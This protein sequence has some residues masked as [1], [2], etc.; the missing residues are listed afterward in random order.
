MTDSKTILITGCSSGIGEALALEFHKRGHRVIATARR[1]ESLQALAATGM[2]TLALDVTDAQSIAAILATLEMEAQTLDILVNNAG[3]GQF[4]ALMDAEPE[5]L[6]HQFE[7]NVIAPVALSRALLPLVRKR[8]DGCIANMGSISGIV[9]TPFAGVYCASKAALHILSD[10]M[11]MEL[12]PFGVR[13]V[14]IQPG[15]IASK[16]GAT[17]ES[18]VRLA[19]DSIYSPIARFILARAKLSQRGAT[20]VDE[21]ARKVVD[22]LLNPD[23]GAICRMGVQSFRLPMLKRWLPTRLLDSKMNKL[24]GL[25]QLSGHKTR[26][27]LQVHLDA[28]TFQGKSSQP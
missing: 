8:K 2:R 13:V 27:D 14:T 22:H 19:P 28:Q 11:R 1:I 3:Y 10:A 4:G 16:F 20:P 7:T 24:F 23:S 9:A 21:F 25:N 26:L 5:D 12:A 17:G 18:H 15:G 6:R